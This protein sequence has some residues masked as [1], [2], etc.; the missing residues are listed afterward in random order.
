MSAST[1]FI[2]FIYFKSCLV[3]Y[4]NDLVTFKIKRLLV[5]LGIKCVYFKCWDFCSS[6]VDKDVENL[7]IISNFIPH[8]ILSLH[9][10]FHASSFLATVSNVCLPYLNDSQDQT[11]NLISNLPF[12]NYSETF[13]PTN[14]CSVLKPL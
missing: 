9:C 7:A 10:C 4:R 6:K 2:L 5:L 13:I 11:M 12:C 1:C 3:G 8:I 14:L